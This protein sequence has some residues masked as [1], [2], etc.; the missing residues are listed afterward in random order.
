MLSSYN[1]LLI[2]IIII[3]WVLLNHPVYVLTYIVNNKFLIGIP[4]MYNK[5]DVFFLR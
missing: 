2:I 1:M 3:V 5:K 4:P